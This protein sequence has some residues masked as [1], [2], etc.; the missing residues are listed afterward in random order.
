MTAPT[1]APFGRVL[2]AMVTPFD[3]DGA[4]DTKAAAR[5]ATHLVDA[6]NDGLVISGTTGES[7]TTTDAEKVQL[8]EAVLDAVG[9]RAYVV[10]G[11]GTN[12]T[13][14][15]CE[16]ARQAAAAGAHGALI[17]T[18]YYSKPPQAGI[19]A[20]TVAV[21]EAGGLPVMLYD[22]PPR[23]NVKLSHET[24]VTLGGHE[25]V[26]AVKDAAGDFSAGAWVM[27]ETDLAYYSG[28]D[29]ANLSWLAYGAVG[30]VSVVAHV[31]SRE[32]AA[33]ITAVDRGDLVEARRINTRLL[34]AVR[35]IMTRTQG[36]ITSKAALQL[37]GVL[38][39]R[40]MRLPLVDLDEPELA[41][42]R[43]DLVAAHLLSA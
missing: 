11:V 19:V 29:A 24:L 13:A 18:P 12:D 8:L 4:L 7:P 28:D 36:A 2:T 5:V 22:I 42:L 34:P 23:T 17:V 1:A 41:P 39:N 9:D 38:D 21:A 20:H 14:H 26:V 16:V 35:A 37:L 27:A 32:Y 30:F 15:S 25:L 31:A 6:G 33:M 3:T 10:A 43:D 40:T